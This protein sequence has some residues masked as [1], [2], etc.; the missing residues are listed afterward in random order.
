M[1]VKSRVHSQVSIS[2][3]PVAN[4]RYKSPLWGDELR[5]LSKAPGAADCLVRGWRMVYP[6][7]LVLAC[8]RYSWER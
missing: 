7:T 5:Y 3:C 4:T 1:D 2:G 6:F 8:E